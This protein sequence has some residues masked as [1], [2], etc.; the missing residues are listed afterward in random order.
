MNEI[1]SPPPQ[2]TCLKLVV[3]VALGGVGSPENAWEEGYN[4]S[5]GLLTRLQP[6]A[7]ASACLL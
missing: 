4:E 7:P 5:A 3:V 2:R 6:L 1:A